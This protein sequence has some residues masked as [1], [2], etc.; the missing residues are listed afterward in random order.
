MMCRS[1]MESSLKIDSTLKSQ[2]RDLESRDFL[3]GDPRAHTH[4]HTHTH[5]THLHSACLTIAAEI[6]IHSENQFVPLFYTGSL[7]FES[8]GF[9]LQLCKIPHAGLFYNSFNSNVI[10]NKSYSRHLLTRNILKQIK[11]EI[12]VKQT[13]H[14]EVNV[15]KKIFI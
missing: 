1:F 10:L 13:S 12:A 3:F 5:T 2:C 8:F 7:W 11:N 15:V 9:G 14:R 6:W 4:T